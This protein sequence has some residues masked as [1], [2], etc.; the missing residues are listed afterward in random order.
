VLCVLFPSF[1]GRDQLGE[2][3]NLSWVTWNWTLNRYK[4][5]CYVK[6][7]NVYDNY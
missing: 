3:S 1:M 5:T 6:I 2:E 4:S 7:F